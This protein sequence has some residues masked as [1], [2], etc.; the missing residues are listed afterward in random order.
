M[1]QI[2]QAISK[3]AFSMTAV[4]L[5]LAVFLWF[6]FGV[7]KIIGDLSGRTAKKSIEK[8]RLAKER[9]GRKCYRPTEVSSNDTAP[10]SLVDVGRGQSVAGDK[11]DRFE[12]FEVLQRIVLIHTEEVIG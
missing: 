6:R 12:T 11:F 7:W 5:L 2:Y 8:M 1:A 9:S 4:S 3:A 10:L